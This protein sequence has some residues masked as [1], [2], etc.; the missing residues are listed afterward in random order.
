MM[1]ESVWLLEE[2]FQSFPNYK[3]VLFATLQRVRDRV[4]ARA[5]VQEEMEIKA[6]SGNTMKQTLNWWDLMWFGFSAML[7]VFCYTEFT[8]EITVEIP[9]AVAHGW[10]SYFVTLI[11]KDPS[12]LQIETNLTSGYNQLDPIAI[13]ILIATGAVAIW[14]TKGT[15]YLNWV[16]TFVNMLILIFVIIAVLTMAE[17]TK[18]TGRDIPIGLLGSMT[19]FTVLYVLMAL[20]LCSMVPTPEI[21]QNAPYSVA[22]QTVGMSW[23]KYVVALGALKGITTVLLVGAVGQA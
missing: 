16:A 7:S 21:D 18:N 17:E 11:N 6:W 15:S 14:S 23:V 2:S 1:K 10:I 5:K 3:R 20:T 22:F 19:I 12:Q 13:G 4:L 9:V 8:V